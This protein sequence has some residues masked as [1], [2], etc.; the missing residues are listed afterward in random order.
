MYSPEL[1]A[2]IEAA[3]A[4]GVLTDKE[5]EVLRKRALAEGVDLDEFDIMVE[6]RLAKMKRTE[7]WLRP[8]P[9]KQSMTEKM[10]NL[11]KCPS[12]GAV[13][14]TGSAVCPDCGYAFTNVK[15]SSSIEKLHEKIENF[16]RA[17]ANSIQ[18]ERMKKSLFGGPDIFDKFFGNAN[19]IHKSKMDIIAT[20]PVPNSRADLL[21]FLTMI[22][23]SVNSVGPRMGSSFY[24]KEEDMSYAYWLLYENCINKAQVSFKNDPDF[25]IY[26][27]LYAKESAKA[28]TI[29][30]FIRS[31][32]KLTMILVIVLFFV[33]WGLIDSFR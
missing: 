30:G 29:L 12:C 10:G 21:E 7:D 8:A 14:N 11:V 5:R 2:I 24:N 33:I 20:F 32:P 23:G 25:A 19:P 26:F 28:K 1:E 4:D 18:S 6:G 31:N 17:N 13:V 16:N 9:P 22:A 3:L 15:A 27:D